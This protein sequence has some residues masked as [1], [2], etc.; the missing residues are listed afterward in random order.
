MWR[1]RLRAILK[2]MKKML[3]KI[4]AILLYCYIAIL[5]T[6]A[7]AISFGITEAGDAAVKGGYAGGTTE[8]TL[9]ETVGL[10]IK[11]ALSLV[12]AIFLALMVYAG[13][14]WMTARGEEEPVTK[15]RKIITACII[16]LIIVVGAY[17]ITDYVLVRVY[18]SVSP[19]A[20]GLE[21]TAPLET[22]ETPK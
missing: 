9:A 19:N 15:A 17:S 14:L 11:M 3:Y 21:A 20:Q 8:T 1:G 10:G 12:G 22:A 6:Q 18:S 4:I 7:L 5:P 16:G 13:Y 2:I